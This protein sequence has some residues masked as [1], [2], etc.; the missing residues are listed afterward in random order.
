MNNFGRLTSK[1]PAKRFVAQSRCQDGK[2]LV[3]SWQL[4]TKECPGIADSVIL[5]A[6]DDE[7][8]TTR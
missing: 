2:A 6:I 4:S 8:D 1:G 5:G 7:E 3:T